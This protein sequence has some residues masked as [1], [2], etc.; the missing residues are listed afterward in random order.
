MPTQSVG[1]GI[2]TRSVGTR[3]AT[4]TIWVVRSAERGNEVRLFR[5]FDEKAPIFTVAGGTIHDHAAPNTR[6][7]NRANPALPN[8]CRF[9]DFS[10]FT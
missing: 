1:D 8:I 6:A 4:E 9:I 7:F 3:C 2:P 10:R 5:T